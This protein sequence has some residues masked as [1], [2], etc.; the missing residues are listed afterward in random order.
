M[1]FDA[2][3][4]KVLIA[5][6]G[7]V[8]EEREAIPQIISEWNITNSESNSIV[9]MPIKWETSSAP[10]MGNRAQ[11]IVNEQ[12]VKSC[13]MVIGVFWTR[14]GT[15]TGVSESGTA[16]EIE[17]FIDN[18][19]PAMIYF[20]SRKVD[21]SK[22]DIEQYKAL[23]DFQGKM[24]KIGLIGSYDSLT[25]FREQ[26]LRQLSVN[27]QLLISGASFNPKKKEEER[28]K[29]KELRKI[30]KQGKIFMEDYKKNGKVK[31]I[32]IKGDTKP[33]KDE[34]KAL[35]G[36]WN[37]SLRGWIFPKSKEVEVAEFIK[38]NS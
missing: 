4:Y 32:L 38:K 2:K 23:K 6:P 33:I 26:L 35:G 13:D 16:E 22:L 9:L 18:G 30:L 1:S 14:L 12:L 20:S 24:R 19:K 15:A 10:L 34:I 25:D 5:S 29:A 3:V 37:R 27:V 21:L 31:S 36:K 7:D 8:N 28:E 11:G 17:W